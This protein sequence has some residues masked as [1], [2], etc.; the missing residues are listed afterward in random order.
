MKKMVCFLAI[1]TLLMVVACGGDDDTEE[2]TATPEP[3][4]AESP[5][6]TPEPTTDPNQTPTPEPTVEPTPPTPP[7]TH[8]PT[9]EPTVA[10]GTDSVELVL[11]DVLP[12]LVVAFAEVDGTWQGY[13]GPN[14]EVLDTL[15]AGEGYYWYSSENIALG[16][17]VLSPM[18]NIVAWT[19]NTGPIATAL[20]GYEQA[21]PFVISPDV[22]AQQ[23]YLYMSSAVDPLAVIPVGQ[24]YTVVVV[25]P[26]DP[27]PN[28]ST[29]TR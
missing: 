26:G 29:D 25:D 1:L 16:T 13:T 2:P 21:I 6:P 9:V 22:Q 19:S 23:T 27:R 20:D 10:A 3:T 7:V 8:E 15:E 24:T 28:W 17:N 4:Q 5:T 18:W 14:A 12:N 11:A